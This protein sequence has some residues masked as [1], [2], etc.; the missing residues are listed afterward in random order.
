ML[1]DD[2]TLSRLM[3]DGLQT[4]P[5]SMNR[6]PLPPQPFVLPLG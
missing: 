4:V 6:S 5:G 1:S 2:D 3:A